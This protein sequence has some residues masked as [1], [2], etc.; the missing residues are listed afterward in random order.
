MFYVSLGIVLFIFV[1]SLFFR[2]RFFWFKF[3]R[4]FFYFSLLVV[5]IFLLVLS[6]VQFLEW[7]Q[8]D[9]SKYLLPP[10]QS[11]N[12]FIFYCFS[13]FFLSYIISAA[14][15]FSFLYAAKFLN[16]KYEEKFFYPEELYFGALGIFLSSFP[17]FI[18][19]VVFLIAVYLITHL[20]SSL[21]TGRSSE[22]LSLY[23]LWLP[24][25]LFAIIINNYIVQHL[26]IWQMLKV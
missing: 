18:F 13:R 14:G 8:D 24:I 12:Y 15:A 23:Y 1:A 3:I 4:L 20:Y 17:G 22:R 16:K 7:Q 10:H 25:V 11:I 26:P 21:F 19:Y 9:F 6:L 5:F 2:G